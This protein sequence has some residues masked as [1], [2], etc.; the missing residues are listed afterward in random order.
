MP[1]AVVSITGA[2][3]NFGLRPSLGLDRESRHWFW[4]EP[5]ICAICGRPS[6]LSP[7]SCRWRLQGQRPYVCSPVTVRSHEAACALPPPR[8]AISSLH[9]RVALARFHATHTHQFLLVG[10]VFSG[11]YLLNSW[12]SGR[13]FRPC[14]IVRRHNALQNSM[15]L[16]TALYP[17]TRYR[18]EGM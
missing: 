3:S 18:V 5:Q 2:G 17:D 12:Q 8:A 7:V 13:P 11:P 16:Y 10:I 15:D 14:E 6:R 4:Q 9:R 1:L